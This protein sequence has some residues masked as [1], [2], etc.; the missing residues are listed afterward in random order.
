MKPK[1]DPPV[2]CQAG[3]KEAHLQLAEKGLVDPRD[4][5][6]LEEPDLSP[7]PKSQIVR[8]RSIDWR[9]LWSDGERSQSALFYITDFQIPLLSIARQEY[10]K[11]YAIQPSDLKN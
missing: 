3:S 7:K 6:Y 1:T 10:S 5:M 8:G 2:P 4:V 9:I 11:P